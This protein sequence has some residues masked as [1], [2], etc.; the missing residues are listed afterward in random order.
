M[1]YNEL[2]LI[3]LSMNILLS[4]YK[5]YYVSQTI[6]PAD[7]IVKIDTKLIPKINGIKLSNKDRFKYYFNSLLGVLAFITPFV[8]TVLIAIDMDNYN[9]WCKKNPNKDYMDYA[10]YKLDKQYK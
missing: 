4:A 1:S 3:G 5:L 2:I 6:S 7:M 10:L 8:S 9:R